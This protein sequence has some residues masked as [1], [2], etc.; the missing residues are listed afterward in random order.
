MGATQA[1]ILAQFLSEAVLISVAGGVAGIVTGGL[2]SMAIQQLAGIKTL[3][4]PLSVIVAF[5]VSFTVGLVFGI[6]PAHRAAKQ[7]PIT[8]LRYE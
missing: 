2:L 1:N 3:V 6:V 5:G 7:D 8:C 4:S